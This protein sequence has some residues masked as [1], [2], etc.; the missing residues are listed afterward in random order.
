LSDLAYLVPVLRRP[1]RVQPLLDSILVAKPGRVVFI[2]DPDDVEEQAAIG[3][4]ITSLWISQIEVEGNY[5]EKINA[6]VRYTTERLLFL[7]ADDLH[8]HPGW[9]EAASHSLDD[10][11]GVVGTQDLCNPRVI[12]GHHATHFLARREY[13]ERG[14]IDEPGA[15][16]H[17]GY[18]HCFVDNEF[19]ETARHRDAYAF[20]PASIVEH[21]HPL[22]GKAE[23]DEVYAKGMAHFARDRRLYNRRRR[24]WT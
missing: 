23:K 22:A 4:S 11:I 20:A 16:L 7:G 3:A 24:L 13:L 5:A 2:C 19:I 1:H 15:P 14:T 10:G 18:T 9:F 12:A 17:E 6:A 8:F 21:L